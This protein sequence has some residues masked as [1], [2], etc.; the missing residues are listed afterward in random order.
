[1][2]A[3]D[4]GGFGRMRHVRPAGVCVRSAADHRPPQTGVLPSDISF[5]LTN[6]KMYVHVY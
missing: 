4:E 1:M 2:S 5:L 6:A 3:E